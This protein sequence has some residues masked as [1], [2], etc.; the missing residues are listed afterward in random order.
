MMYSFYATARH[1]TTEKVIISLAMCNILKS[2]IEVS[3]LRA[4]TLH[5]G[6]QAR[7]DAKTQRT[8]ENWDL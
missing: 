1:T 6:V 5:L 3:R 7:K 2:D 8:E 4:A